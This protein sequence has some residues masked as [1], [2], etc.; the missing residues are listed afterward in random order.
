M[1]RSSA[2]AGAIAALAV[3]GLGTAAASAKSSSGAGTCRGAYVMAVDDATLKKASDALLCL[4]NRERATRGLG[5]MR[6]SDKLATAAKSHSGDMVA[7]KFF[8]HTGPDGDD[9]SQRVSRT[10]YPW[11]AVAETMAYGAAKRSTPFRLVASMM[12]SGHAPLDP[13]RAPLSR[14]WRR[15]RAR[16]ADARRRS[17]RV[18][19][20]A[21]LRQ[22]LSAVANPPSCGRWRSATTSAR[23]ARGSRPRR[24]M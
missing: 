22:P 14:A 13:A 17:G 24:G 4:V 9:V 11:T 10:G 12:K 2:I 21:R 20:H 18:D 19:A 7:G 1:L 16:R 5:A 3:C 15:A 23:P 8:S 6:T